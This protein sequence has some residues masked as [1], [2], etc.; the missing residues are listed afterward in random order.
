MTN[1]ILYFLIVPAS[2]DPRSRRGRWP[3]RCCHERYES[4]GLPSPVPLGPQPAAREPPQ[5]RG[6]PLPGHGGERSPHHPESGQRHLSGVQALRPPDEVEIGT[7]RL[8]GNK[9]PTR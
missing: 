1:L 6:G 3:S 5:V 2:S 9:Y 7:T 4:H 8:P